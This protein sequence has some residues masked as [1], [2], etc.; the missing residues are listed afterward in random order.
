MI[1]NKDVNIDFSKFYLI[2]FLKNS[3]ETG[4]ET[5]P[6][7]N[8]S[9]LDELSAYLVKEENV[10][11]GFEKLARYQGTN[12]FS[13]FL[14]DMLDHLSDY[15]PT[16]AYDRIPDLA[17]DFINLYNLMLEETE[18][19]DA[20]QDVLK[21]YRKERPELQPE[22]TARETEEPEPEQTRKEEPD[23][24]VEKEEQPQV[25][26][27]KDGLSFFDFYEKEFADLLHSKI[28]QEKDAEDARRYCDLFHALVRFNR[29][30]D[31]SQRDEYRNSITK[32]AAL[33]DKIFPEQQKKLPALR[34]MR[35]L[36]KQVK[37][38]IGQAKRFDRYNKKAFQA[39]IEKNE[40]TKKQ[41]RSAKKKE[42]KEKAPTIETVLSDYF[43]SE[44]NHH[45]DEI[46]DQI[47]TL[48][49]QQRISEK[50]IEKL[51]VSF[52]SLKEVSM[53]HGYGGIEHLTSVITKLL[54][55][56]NK[57]NIDFSEDSFDILREIIEK[58]R[59]V[60][61]FDKVSKDD[62][63]ILE[64]ENKIN[65]IA[66]TVTEFTPE[67]EPE[68]VEEEEK[69]AEKGDPKK[70]KEGVEEVTAPPPADEIAFTDKENL[71]KIAAET[72]RSVHRTVD[73]LQ[74]YIS[75]TQS[76]KL[77]AA[78]ANRLHDQ[79]G[80]I[81][82]D[83]KSHFLAPLRDLY[84]ECFEDTD[85]VESM[86][87]PLENIWKKALEIIEEPEKMHTLDP[88]FESAKES[89]NV[90]VETGGVFALTAD[91]KIS[92]A[93]SE[94]LKARWQTQKNAMSDLFIKGVK[95]QQDSLTRF[96]KWFR[97]NLELTGYTNFLPF[98][99]LFIDLIEDHGDITFDD[100]I[101][102]ELENSV[103]LVL[104][105]VAH[106]GRS[107]D[108]ADITAA[109]EELIADVR[110]AVG[111]VEEAEPLSDAS[112]PAEKAVQTEKP[113][114]ALPEEA[115]EE[116]EDV[117]AI[118]YSE[119]K[120][121]LD[122]IN[123]ALEMLDRDGN[124]REQ[125]AIIETAVH[126]I[127][128][129]AHL[130]NLSKVAKI[131]ALIEEI[132]EIYG[133]SD[134][135]IPDDLATRVR[136]GVEDLKIVISDP[137]TDIKKT[138]ES[139]QYLVDHIVIEDS[140]PTTT[141]A[142]K[143]VEKPKE[144]VAKGIEEQPLFLETEKVD[145]EFLDIFREE[146]SNYL[147]IIED[148]NHKMI[149]NL[150]DLDSLNDFENAAH[151]LK[152][153]AKMIGF[154]E[155]GQLTDAMEQIS[156]SI[157]I[158]EIKNSVEIQD[159]IASAIDLIKRLS[160]GD[161]V[162][163]NEMITVLNNLNPSY[164]SKDISMPA[165]E[166]ESYDLQRDSE[167][168]DVFLL[169]SSEI[170]QA[171]NEDLLELE[172]APASETVVTNILRN[173]HTLKGSAALFNYNKIKDL[174]HKLEDYFQIYSE[175]RLDQ[176][177]EMLNSAFS[178]IDLISE[179]L[180][181]IKEGRGEQVEQFTSRMAE[182]DNRLFLYRNFGL[183]APKETES[184]KEEPK[185][186]TVSRKKTAEDDNVIRV[187]TEY[188]D[189]LVDMAADLMINQTQLNTNLDILQTITDHIESE[190]KRIKNIESVVEEILE[191]DAT[192]SE[193]VDEI[194][195][196]N[197]NLKGASDVIHR[198]ASELTRL[199]QNIEYSSGRI[200][201]LSKLLHNDILKTRMIP[202]EKLFNR[203]PRP[204]RDMAK[205]QGKRIKLTIEGGA[206]EMDR[207]MIEALNDPV[208]HIIRN[209]VDH[210]IEKPAERTEL[211]KDKTGQLILKAHHDKNQVVIEIEDDGRGINLSKVREKIIENN[212][213]SAA[214]VEKM[215]E[216]EILDYL[217]HTGFTTRDEATDVSGRGIGLDVVNLQI[218][219]LKGNI[220]IRTELGQGTT[221]SIR[222]P[223][224]LLISQA[225]LVEVHGQKIAIPLT[226][227]QETVYFNQNEIEEDNG[228]KF[229][230]VR[231]NYLPF[232]DLNELLSFNGG[233]VP[234]TAKN[235]AVI[236][237]DAGISVALGVNRIMERQEIVV[238]SLGNH[239]QNVEYIAGGTIL[240]SGEVGLILDYATVIRTAEVRY[241][242]SARDK[243][244]Y[245]K[246][247]GPVRKAEK[248][249]SDRTRATKISKKDFGKTVVKDRKPRIL[250]V[251]DSIS[252]RNFVGS[253]LERNKYDT[254]KSSNG[255]DAWEKLKESD[256]D[257]MIT[258]LEMP[259]MH[260]FELIARIRENKAY[261]N[262][263]IIILTGRA[264]MKD[265]QKS[266]SLGANS[267]LV[268][269]FKENDLLKSI[270][271]FVVREK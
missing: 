204:V 175:K 195:S 189:K 11:E 77:L 267:F 245:R 169:E 187:H 238:K 139:L 222:V 128:S 105:R 28:E 121:H 217:F 164:F 27:M 67:E 150:E 99:T 193:D 248:K 149:Q 8:L 215:S 154:K 147:K 38:F 206:T 271:D 211:N 170:I 79:M 52:K 176:K 225:L 265:R 4:K 3:L 97:D 240:G 133:Q 23:V 103:Q 253:I 201:N 100:E 270:S 171:L 202:V 138:V 237:H 177:E 63:N 213:A 85:R 219:K 36:E 101:V 44:A 93:L 268:K 125:Y 89:L 53:I 263:P 233:E 71:L 118:F 112:I 236:V 182:I 190:K 228:K 168:T 198:V 21:M 73:A 5:L 197:D 242:G 68:E 224:T 223:L 254:T 57:P 226:A 95:E 14:F 173:L 227:V 117:T 260:G 160:K 88:L 45:I 249:K 255:A 220:R 39:I 50:D 9:L 48:K 1:F 129:S 256:F 61:R 82:E 49:D 35:N 191:E 22:E 24:S 259:E 126:D 250:I 183:T 257:L 231:G 25:P 31:P 76:Q 6:G 148:A 229:L 203:Y 151:S 166:E 56:L 140:Q 55:N 261:E 84:A 110:K 218:Q 106:K 172:Q 64:I 17:N 181:A 155:I 43:K 80:L 66:D 96:F 94:V 10:I 108:C 119:V 143:E 60:S 209:A 59:D 124:D 12:E 152:S 145:K 87:E 58:F 178:A 33:M 69:V 40:F 116:E 141:S 258:D 51:I 72:L 104:E 37:K 131:S 135:R 157:K 111:K 185:K 42:Q 165:T 26:E 146:A 216:A 205:E 186:T 264:G 16:A 114:T 98:T 127:R 123:G 184:E 252:V 29:E 241:F 196:I 62:Q 153:S 269:P 210:G 247:T 34:L 221:F 91:E 246:V 162:S 232:I 122:R 41:R 235:M 239:L 65:S 2:E 130:L 234:D 83:L 188:L 7:D 251:D 120:E 74:K 158:K 199:N 47:N 156:E 161:Q 136:S 208:M 54:T 81:D 70:D 214:D 144:P 134:I 32:L 75:D 192:P 266:E 19:V 212:L 244:G 46:E 207:A 20:I 179:L 107:G 137:D 167:M 115:A 243:I 163:S 102:Y 90:P 113:E 86:R 15:E 262:L 18:C 142:E 109:L 13:I 159:K 78:L 174:S 92:R 230:S 180:S 30:I 132:A 194:R 200:S